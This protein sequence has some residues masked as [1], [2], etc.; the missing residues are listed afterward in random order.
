MLRDVLYGL[1]IF[2]GYYIIA[3]TILLIIKKLLNP[4]SELFRKSLHFICFMSV[5]ILLYAIDVWYVSMLVAIIFSIVLYPVIDFIE[6]FPN[7]IGIFNQRKSGEIKSSLMTVFFMMAIL[8]AIF[9][10][11]LGEQWK[12][13]I[14]VSIMS[15]GF[16]DAAAALVGKKW[17]SN[18]I[19][20]KWV[21]GTKTKEGTFAMYIVS[22]V[23]IA[24]NLII[25]SSIPWYLCIICALIVA[26]IC[27]LVELISHNG[28]D[29]ITVPFATAIP[30]FT[31]LMIF[32]STGGI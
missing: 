22:A 17:G 11:I 23:T 26:P 3:A 2:I 16:G 20:H 21:E 30:L 29:T 25:Y 32:S 15:W 31:I 5:F 6:E 10:G 4:P 27:A 19:S 12:Y 13:I 9:W 18:P 28:I 14:V 1:G 7:I 8:I 24:I